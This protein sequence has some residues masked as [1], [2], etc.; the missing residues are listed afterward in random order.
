MKLEELLEG[1][2]TCN[3]TASYNIG[4]KK[5]KDAEIREKAIATLTKN[6]ES[7]KKKAES[8]NTGYSGGFTPK[9]DRE[10]SHRGMVKYR[11]EERTRVLKA[12]KKLWEDGTPLGVMEKFRS[13]SEIEMVQSY[14]YPKEQFDRIL[15][16]GTRKSAGSARRSTKARPRSC[17]KAPSPAP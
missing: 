13:I 10:A 8:I 1:N 16:I 6:I 7:A 5:A 14:E 12:L 11:L 9:R 2:P 4:K 3:L 17:T 15:L